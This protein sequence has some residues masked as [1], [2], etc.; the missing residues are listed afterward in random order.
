MNKR[1]ENLDH[2]MREWVHSMD[3]VLE[4][5]VKRMLTWEVFTHGTDYGHDNSVEMNMPHQSN[6]A[7]EAQPVRKPETRRET[8]P[9]RTP[10][11][12]TE[13]CADPC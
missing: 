3:D 12:A 2:K 6:A 10:L 1:L 9:A 5:P 8:R 7:A 4:E 13:P 11:P